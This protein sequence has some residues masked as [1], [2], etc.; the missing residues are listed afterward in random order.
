[1]LK[2]CYNNDG[3]LLKLKWWL[4]K[5][6]GDSSGYLQ[7]RRFTNIDDNKIAF[8]LES[9]TQTI[10]EDYFSNAARAIERSNY[11]GKNI[12]E[13]D[14][15]QIQ[16]IIKELTG[17]GMS[18]TEA[19]SVADRLRKMHRRVTGIETYMLAQVE[20]KAKTGLTC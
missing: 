11:F 3:H 7:A 18:M 16:P 12:V 8:V 19:Q 4:N 6:V 20:Q 17:S 1:M 13:F 10:L 9:D 15:N 2:I 14:N 5:V